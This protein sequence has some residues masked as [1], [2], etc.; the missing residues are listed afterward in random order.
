MNKPKPAQFVVSPH[1]LDEAPHVHSDDADVVDALADVQD[2]FPSVYTSEEQFVPF[3]VSGV[4]GVGIRRKNGETLAGHAGFEV[5]LVAVLP[6]TQVL[7]RYD[8]KVE[9][10]SPQRRGLGKSRSICDVRARNVDLVGNALVPPPEDDVCIRLLRRDELWVRE[11]RH[12]LFTGIE[13]TVGVGIVTDNTP[14]YGNRQSGGWNN[15]LGDLLHI[16]FGR[17]GTGA[18]ET[19]ACGQ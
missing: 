11:R 15:R 14:P 2:F 9:D 16:F 1:W 3:R 6:N 13:H 8:G 5:E 18:G 10:I 12:S 19:N 4:D 7:V 17:S